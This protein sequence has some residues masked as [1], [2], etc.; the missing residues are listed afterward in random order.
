MYNKTKTLGAWYSANK[1]LKKLRTGSYAAASDANYA[2]D[3]VT[4]IASLAEASGF[5]AVLQDL[6]TSAGSSVTLPT[7][8]ELAETWIGTGIPLEI[9]MGKLIYDTV[10]KTVVNGKTRYKQDHAQAVALFAEQLRD[11]IRTYRLWLR[12]NEDIENV[13]TKDLG[14]PGGIADATKGN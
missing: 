13:D 3:L 12:M 7:I 1:F 8:M 2:T 14:N 9:W 10:T 11:V 6:A 5:M 4:R